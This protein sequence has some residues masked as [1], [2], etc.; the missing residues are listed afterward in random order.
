MI[1][2]IFARVGHEAGLIK[3]V[4]DDNMISWGYFTDHNIFEPH[5]NAHPNNFLVLDLEASYNTGGNLLAPIDFDMTYEYATFVSTVE[6][7]PHYGTRDREQF[8]SWSGLEK[9]ELE[10][11]LGGAENMANFAY[12]QD[13]NISL[14]EIAL[15]DTCVGH[16]RR[17]YDT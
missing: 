16:Y 1:A 9:Y 12:G 6:D 8:D 3:R 5:C 11:A 4:M 13:S 14:I 15:R 17:A 7:S 2:L 10:K